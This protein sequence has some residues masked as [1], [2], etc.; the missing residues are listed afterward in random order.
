MA[1]SFLSAQPKRRSQIVAIDLGTRTTKAV[2]LQRRGQ[3]FELLRYA[4]QDAPTRDQAPSV[5]A[6]SDHLKSLHQALDTRAK[7]VV[8]IAGVNDTLLRHADVPMMPLAD[9][10]QM[11]RFSSK[12][13]LQQD[14][15]DHFFDCYILP[16]RGGTGATEAGKGTKCRV[17]VGGA[18][19]QFLDQL[20]E[21]A[22]SAGLIPDQITPNLVGPPNAFEMAQPDI[23][24]K[25]VIA[26][27]DIGFKNS[28]INLLHHGELSLSR[29]VQIGS[30]RLTSGLAESMG[31]N[32]ADAETAKLEM[33][34]DA[35]AHLMPS[36]MPLGREL[37]ASI[38]F[39][40]KQ[41]DKTISQVFLSGGAARS[42]FII[43]ALQSELMVPC[44]S[45][46]PASFLTLALPPQQ[47]G[48]LEPLVPQL[49]VAI[50][51]AVAAL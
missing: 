34:D 8:L 20:Q 38:D 12:N 45:W 29:V 41:E 40:E 10:R 31:L 7:E 39:F 35:R 19:K 33:T 15:P 22:K 24:S 32:Y 51:G 13:Y 30:D 4:I 50:G 11:L 2:A 36:I 48:E 5:Q 9:M 25:E 47:M 16:P 23:F 26:L 21:A 17:L 18:K 44:K 43:E 49:A 27:V 37:R 14:L 3:S 46:N 28:T 6:L 1:L 42:P